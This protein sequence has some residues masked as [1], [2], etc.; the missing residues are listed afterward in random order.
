MLKYLFFILFFAGLLVGYFIMD[1]PAEM[2]YQQVLVRVKMGLTLVFTGG[3]GSL[4]CLHRI[5]R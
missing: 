4:V 2:P 5:T 3:I 1:V